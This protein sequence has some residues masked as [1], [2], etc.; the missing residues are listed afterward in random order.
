MTIK[1]V[2]Y[3]AAKRKGYE[4]DAP[5]TKR[6]AINALASAMGAEKSGSTIAEAM[7]IVGEVIAPKPNEQAVPLPEGGL[8]D[9]G[10]D[11]EQ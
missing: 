10:K 8:D 2:I 3:D 4:G 5:T 9:S 7:D 11:P 6:E 1:E